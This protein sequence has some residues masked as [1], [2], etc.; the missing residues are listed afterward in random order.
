MTMIVRHIFRLR[1][2]WYKEEFERDSCKDDFLLIEQEN[3]S[4]YIPKGYTNDIHALKKFM[5]I[6][7]CNGFTQ[8]LVRDN[9]AHVSPTRVWCCSLRPRSEELWLLVQGGIS[10]ARQ[11]YLCGNRIPL[12][13]CS[14]PVTESPIH[15]PLKASERWNCFRMV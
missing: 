12:P 2:K 5:F 7:S 11:I 15:L 14:R 8:W 10:S 1:R 9:K 4:T 6:T 13:C 3:S